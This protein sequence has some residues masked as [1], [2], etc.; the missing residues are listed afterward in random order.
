MNTRHPKRISRKAAEQL[1]DGAAGLGRGNPRAPGGPDQL[2]R[3]L[4]A[5][6]A[7]GRED[8]L[9]GEQMAV[10]AFEAGHLVPVAS[11]QRG[12]MIKYSTRVRLITGKV[13]AMSLLAAAATGGVALAASTGSFSGPGPSSQTPGPAPSSTSAAAGGPRVSPSAA[14][15]A[16]TSP[17]VSAP[18]PQTGPQPPAG[19]TAGPRNTSSPSDS[20]SAS[21]VPQT[22]TAL[23]HALISD[24]S[25][26]S[27]QQMGQA[28][29]VATLASGAVPTVLSS[30]SE[31][32]PLISTAQSAAAVPDYCALV[33][34]LPQ[35]PQPGELA[36]LPEPVL[37][38]LLT[39]LPA[40]TA[41]AIITE[42][43]STVQTQILN[44][45]PA[46]TVSQLLNE[47]PSSA[48][49]TLNGLSGLTGPVSSLLSGL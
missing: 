2:A 47:M 45:L 27:S 1:L 7:P 14:P 31:F 38:A 49:S 24:A 42:L 39:E 4:A 16:T 43:P 37:S 6:A 17:G 23:C 5:A 15:T 26:T 19:S 9:A 18:A 21:S 13:L 36:Q 35:M 30:N 10:A 11:S 8:E 28:A 22:A 34:D 41:T 48:V 20:P 46:S 32:S 3:V 12:Q 29:Q 25:G 40:S 33:L 44:E